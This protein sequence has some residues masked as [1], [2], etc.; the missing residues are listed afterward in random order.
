MDI[1]LVLGTAAQDTLAD[2]TFQAAWRRLYALCPWG[3]LLQSPDFC[4]PWYEIYRDLYAPLL[5][6]ALDS[7]GEL[8]GLFTLAVSESDGQLVVAGA[9][10]AEY[11]V[12]ISTPEHGNLFIEGA[13]HT[14]R[15]QFPG[16]SLRLL[17]LPSKA[18]MEWMA[19]DRYWAK[20]CHLRM[21]SHPLMAIG[22]GAQVRDT[23]QKKKIRYRF[24]RLRQE[25]GEL[26]LQRITTA[27]E[28]DA[29]LDEIYTFSNFRLAAF[30][31]VDVPTQP[32]LRQRAL[33]LRLIQTPRIVH[34]TLF[35]AGEHI[36]G[37]HIN[38]Y[39]RE[40]VLLGLLAYS[41]LAGKHSPGR[42][43]ILLLAE[44]LA[45]EGVSTLDL[46][47]GGEYKDNFA[48]HFDAAYVL[49]VFFDR[50]GYLNYKATRLVLDAGKR[51]L[52]LAAISPE[53]IK[54]LSR[55]V[56]GKLARTRLSRLPLK[57][58]RRLKKRLWNTGEMRI[59]VMDSGGVLRLPKPQ[60]MKRDCVEDLLCY[61]PAEGW[62]PPKDEFLRR[63]AAGLENGDHIYTYAEG[64]RLLH[65]GWLV[66]RQVESFLA[67]VGQASYLL[68][69]SA[70]LA[71]FY[72]HPLARGRGLYQKSLPQMLH[73]AEAIPG[74]QRI[75]IGVMADNG[76]SRHVIEKLGFVYQHSF[77]ERRRPTGS[78]RWTNAPESAR[79]AAPQP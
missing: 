35:K 39:N 54:D 34:A 22:D 42:L 70:V 28:L 38:V 5:V 1:Q 10:M 30:H 2:P 76:P 58:A 36:V 56:R 65:Y 41:P 55:Q 12:W 26:K 43:H 6:F 16:K 11:Q 33:Y 9:G 74:T 78:R 51:I 71:D 79:A 72:T 66:E 64:G 77:F 61:E 7:R 21:I 31:K 4:L 47:P 63:A 13:L 37:A 44:E 49:N 18:P 8:S 24:N 53:R 27:D 20:T 48:T 32:D 69:D 50:K 25:M 19:A 57:F 23:L 14:L 15:D 3:T 29:V 59:Y 73:D 45:K 46:T 52:G 17:F 60:A 68:P 62:Q 75:Y 40:Q 67:E